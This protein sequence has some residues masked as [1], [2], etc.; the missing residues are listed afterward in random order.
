M[1]RT[2]LSLGG[3]L[4]DYLLDMG[5]REDEV[6]RRLREETGALEMARMQISPEQGALM[7]MLIRVLGARRA[8][9]IGVFTG[10]STLSVAKALPEDGRVVACDISEEWT[11]IAR[12][13]WEEA[14]VAHKIDLRLRPALET[15]DALLTDGAQGSF[16][17]AFIDADKGGY[18]DYYERCLQ[19][20]RA[21]GLIAVDNVL[22]GG[23]VV[24]A[25]DTEED[26]L[27]IRQFNTALRHD[28]RID[29]SLVP[30]GDGVTLARKR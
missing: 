17:F 26:T 24:D 25:D 10:Y 6:Q 9:E 29:V 15:L 21:G 20:L 16:D 12:R 30:I 14:G 18:L 22:W 19:L 2:T 5:V 4:Y 8:L 28:N 7:A 13:Y 3:A 23:K 11:A 1:S 27:A